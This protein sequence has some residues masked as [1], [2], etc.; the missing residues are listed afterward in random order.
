[1]KMTPL[2]SALSISNGLLILLPNSF[3]CHPTAI[4]FNSFLLQAAEFR[5]QGN[6]VPF[7]PDTPAGI[8]L[9]GCGT[10]GGTIHL[11]RAFKAEN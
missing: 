10:L 9:H 6:T 4:P 8:G 7:P 2:L 11:R 1:M 3:F 5:M